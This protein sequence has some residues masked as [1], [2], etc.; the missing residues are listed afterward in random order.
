MVGNKA[1]ETE[2]DQVAHLQQAARTHG[3]YALRDRGGEALTTEQAATY[4]ELRAQFESAPGRLAYRQHLAAMLAMMLELGFSHLRKVAEDGRDIWD[5]GATKRMAVYVN[6]LQR[7]MDGF[8]DEPEHKHAI[9][10]EHI[11]E[12]LNGKA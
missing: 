11:D 6:S 8:P 7:L 10:L 5:Q 4:R 1:H 9:E 2:F 12:V 3:M